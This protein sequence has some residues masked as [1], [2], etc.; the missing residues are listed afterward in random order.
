MLRKKLMLLLLLLTLLASVS[1]TTDSARACSGDNC[2]CG[3][4]M[5]ICDAN[6][7][8]EPPETE[9]ACHVACA[10][11]NARCARFCCDPWREF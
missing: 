9:T 7:E 4:D 2:G 10:R 1:T 8:Y 3:Y 6:C 11:E 5:L